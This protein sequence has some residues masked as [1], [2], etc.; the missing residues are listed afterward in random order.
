[1]TDE[2]RI[3]SVLHGERTWRRVGERD[4][5]VGKIVMARFR[6]LPDIL[7]APKSKKGPRPFRAAG[8]MCGAKH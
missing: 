8:L 5:P 4:Q 3:N 2:L 6:S 7:R 1:M